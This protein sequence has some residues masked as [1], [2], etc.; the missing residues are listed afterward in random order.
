MS[1]AISSKLRSYQVN[2]QRDYK[3]AKTFPEAVTVKINTHFRPTCIGCPEQCPFC[4]AVCT[5]TSGDHGSK[6]S[7]M[8]HYPQG[9]GGYKNR[10][11]RRLV[12]DTCSYSVQSEARFRKGEE[13]VP[14]RK[15]KRAFPDWNIPPDPSDHSTM[16]WRYVFARFNA[17][18]AKEYKGKEAEIPP[19]WRKIKVEGVMAS[20]DRSI[21]RS[22]EIKSLYGRVEDNSYGILFSP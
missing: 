18:F 14:Y 16:L 4:G 12:T 20:M 2:E 3:S 21:L 11:S 15:Y 7:S 1:R 8:A 5:W 13:E 17:E 10:E 6:H 9:L 22:G 19:E